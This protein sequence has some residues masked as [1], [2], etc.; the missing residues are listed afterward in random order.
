MTLVIDDKT[1]SGKQVKIHDLG[2]DEWEIWVDGEYAL[3]TGTSI[4]RDGGTRRIWTSRGIITLP[5]K[6]ASV[7]RVPKLDGED[8][9]PVPPEVTAERQRRAQAFQDILRRESG[10]Q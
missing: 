2:N 7:D 9:G 6:I 4:Y 3:V 10:L 5:H 8:I 1:K